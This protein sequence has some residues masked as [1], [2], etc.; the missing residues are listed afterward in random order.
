MVA[1]HRTASP[2]PPPLAV[3]RLGGPAPNWLSVDEAMERIVASFAP[4]D[5][6]ERVPLSDALGRALVE[7]VPADMDVPPFTNVAVD[8]YAVRA[9]DTVAATTARPVTLRVIGRARAEGA[10]A[11]AHAQ[12]V[13]G[14]GEAYRVFTGT[15]LSP[16][17]D[18]VVPYELTD[19]T[20]FGGWQA[21]DAP[22]T[23]VA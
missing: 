10:L 13:V 18:A 5:H 16:G 3:E 17:T 9:E 4:L 22:E 20:G 11:G 12:R 23:A 19:G 6:H 7:D 15:V 21:A 2:L 14:Q 1:V 8:G